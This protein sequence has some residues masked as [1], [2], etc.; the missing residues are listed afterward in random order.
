MLSIGNEVFDHFIVDWNGLKLLHARTLKPLSCKFVFGFYWQYSLK[1][2]FI[3]SFLHINDNI[4]DKNLQVFLES[5][6][7]YNC[8]EIRKQGHGIKKFFARHFTNDNEQKAMF[9][10]CY[11]DLNIRRK[12]I[13]LI[14]FFSGVTLIALFFLIWFMSI[15]D[16]QV[17]KDDE[18]F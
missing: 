12:D 18:S 13:I 6:E 7:F 15:S 17:G 1:K 2:Y 8:T 3:E 4:I 5:Q 10:L 9:E 16:R 11:K 14:S